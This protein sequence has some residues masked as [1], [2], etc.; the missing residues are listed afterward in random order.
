MF[1]IQ[2]MWTKMGSL[3]TWRG[4]RRTWRGSSSATT[5]A[6]PAGLLAS[7]VEEWF[8][9]RGW[10]EESPICLYD[11]GMFYYLFKEQINITGFDQNC[12]GR[13]PSRSTRCRSRSTRASSTSSHMTSLKRWDISTWYL[14][15][16]SII[17]INCYL[18]IISIKSIQWSNYAL[19]RCFT[20]VEFA[21]LQSFLTLIRL[22]P[23]CPAAEPPIKCK[24]FQR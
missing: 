10:G 12:W 21:A 15:I 11:L 16:F 23:T 13:T 20:N 5:P 1:V 14:I 24:Y 9:C 7:F 18:M 22:L 8:N 19:P 3:S 4:T 17:I 2:K 6:M